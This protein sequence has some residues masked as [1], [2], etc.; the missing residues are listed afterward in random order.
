MAGKLRHMRIFASGGKNFELDVVQSTGELLL[1]SNFTISADLRKGRRP[2]LIQA[3]SP[4]HAEPVFNQLV[5]FLRKL[6]V[7]VATGKFRAD[8]V[9][10]ILNDGPVTFCLQ[11]EPPS[12]DCS[13]P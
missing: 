13:T 8:M 4:E 3:A 11:S 1:V 12:P 10:H 9:V 7:R 5:D 6:D 2:D